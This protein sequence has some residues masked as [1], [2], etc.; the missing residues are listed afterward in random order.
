[1][2]FILDALKKSEIERQQQNTDF[3]HIQKRKLNAKNH[4]GFGL[5]SFY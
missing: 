1:M 4:A 3:I 5:L 2:S